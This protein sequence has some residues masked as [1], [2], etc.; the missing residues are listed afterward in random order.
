MLRLR[1][2][3]IPVSHLH[4]GSKQHIRTSSRF[5]KGNLVLTDLLEEQEMFEVGVQ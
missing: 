1:V 3:I 4:L 2:Y 5:N